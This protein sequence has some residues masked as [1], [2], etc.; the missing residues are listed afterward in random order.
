MIRY[1]GSKVGAVINFSELTSGISDLLQ[2]SFSNFSIYITTD[3]GEIKINENVQRKAASLAKVPILLEAFRQIEK[4]NLQANQT[5]SIEDNMKVGGSGVITNLTGVKSLP[6]INLLELMIIVSDNTAANVVLDSVGIESVNQLSETLNCNNTV[7]QRRFMDAEASL[8]GNEN[9]TSAADMI[10]F[11]K[12]IGETNL[13]ISAECRTSIF[14]ILY[15]QQFRDKLAFYLPETSDVHIFHKSGELSGTE[16]EA[17]IFKF[18]GKQLYAVVLSEGWENNGD[19]KKIIAKL[20]K[21][22][23]TYIQS[24]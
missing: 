5:V 18:Q 15:Q 16:H 9:W 20:G 21:L 8:H 22:L 19:G 10:T 7:L 24:N 23:I 3:D 2:D 4:N 12:M 17:A 11:L 1:T 13:L 14:R 6:Y